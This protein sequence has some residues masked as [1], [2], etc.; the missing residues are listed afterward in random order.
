MKIL[1]TTNLKFL[2]FKFFFYF[3]IYVLLKNMKQINQE[4]QWK[5]FKLD[6]RH[7]GVI[8]EQEFQTPGSNKGFK[9]HAVVGVS[10][11]K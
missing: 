4:S 2:S 8:G 11:P 9:S 7:N 5:I 3:R 1:N 6:W 10:N